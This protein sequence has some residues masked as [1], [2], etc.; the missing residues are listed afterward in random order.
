M[1]DFQEQEYKDL[2]YNRAMLL[3]KLEIEFSSSLKVDSEL[4]V[5]I[6]TKLRS[7]FQHLTKLKEEF[8]FNFF[9][10]L[11]CVNTP[12][13]KLELM[14]Q[15]LNM[16]THQR[17]ILRCPV[18]YEDIIPSLSDLF[19]GAFWCEQEAWDM[20]G[21][22]FEEIPRERLLSPDGLVGFPLRSDFRPEPFSLKKVSR[23][24]F[25]PDPRVSRDDWKKREVTQVNL[26]GGEVNGPVRAVLEAYDETIERGR[27]EIGFLHRGLEKIFENLNCI[28]ILPH[29]SRI[30][31][32]C[33]TVY[34]QAW[35]QGIE[36]YLDVY[37]PDR[38]KALRMVFNE[39]DR[40]SEHL[41]S[42][43]RV[44]DALDCKPFLYDALE[45]REAITTVMSKYSGRR[46]PHQLICLG[47][48]AGE[49]PKGWLTECLKLLNFL[50]K[51]TLGITRM[52]SNSTLW[53]DRLCRYQLDSTRALNWGVTGPNLRAS[54]VN[55]DLRKVSPHYFY[56][57][58]EF[59]I[60]LG[61]NGQC[62]DR[63]LVRVEEI[64]QSISIIGQL[65]DNLP[66]GEVQTRDHRLLIPRKQDVH[67]DPEALAQHFKIFDGGPILPE[68]DF[69]SSIES[70][71]GELGFYV[72]SDGGSIPSRVKMR[73][74]GFYA[75]QCF[76][77][78]VEGSSIE[79]LPLIINSL[80]LVM[81]EIDR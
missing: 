80:N 78:V 49:A 48:V 24:E 21:L 41:D 20:Y 23:Y 62:Y 47:G 28:Q 81:G 54:G 50:E 29:I 42:I 5:K 3:E 1:F 65:L 10:N 9:L 56:S 37:I 75:G 70:P 32:N 55:Y 14:V 52:I 17:V 66:L 77:D 53:M 74:P 57:D 79:E 31:T 64:F 25:S 13:N 60:P 44:V 40:I 43:G 68:G 15:L 12:E 34:Q 45:M 58:L 26:F 63:Y 7:Y 76:T 72:K 22:C 69:Y 38:A 67:T 71:N 27:L 33:A 51:K 39:F 6:E 36:Q 8:G 46:L 18:S 19:Q 4:S 73:S 11:W 59:D 2:I 16:D 61:I 35:C 30:N